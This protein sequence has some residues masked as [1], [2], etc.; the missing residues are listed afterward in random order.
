MKPV[1]RLLVPM[2]LS[3]SAYPACKHEVI[4]ATAPQNRFVIESLLA[5]NVV[6]DTRTGLRW[7]RCPILDDNSNAINPENVATL[8]DETCPSSVKTV[9]WKAALEIAGQVVSATRQAWRLP[10]VKELASLIGDECSTPAV[11]SAA[12]PSVMDF[13]DTAA[14]IFELDTHFSLSLVQS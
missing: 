5:L 6:L 1:I 10:N 13:P 7:R 12:F 2:L 3:G 8:F 4:E 11:Q 9:T 14:G